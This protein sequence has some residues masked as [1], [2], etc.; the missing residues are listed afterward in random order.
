MA[1]WRGSRRLLWLGISGVALAATFAGAQIPKTRPVAQED[2]AHRVNE[3][4]LA[5]LRP[6]RDGLVRAAQLNTELGKGKEQLE[7]RRAGWTHAETYR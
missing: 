1:C 7:I 3:M 2:G 5:G 6:G 4:E